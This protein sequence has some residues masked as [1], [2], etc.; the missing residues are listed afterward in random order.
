MDYAFIKD[1]EV[2]NI[3]VFEDSTEEQ[4]LENFKDEL[5]L[6]NIILTTDKAAVGGT[7]D[8]TKFWL[9]KP[10]PSWVKGTDDWEAPVS[11][12]NFNKEEP[13][14]YEWDEATFSWVEIAE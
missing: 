3:V 12:P 6:D 11:Y 9:P 10:Y 4:F 7:Y 13:K 1:G 2:V 14:H 5:L 8:G